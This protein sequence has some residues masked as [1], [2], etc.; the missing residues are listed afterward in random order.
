MTC[1]II[2]IDSQENFNNSLEEFD[3]NMD[4]D[5]I[6][7]FEKTEN[8]Y[9]CFYKKMPNEIKGFFI[10]INKQQLIINI[11]QK[12]IKLVSNSTLLKNELL[13]LIHSH[14]VLNCI[15]YSLKSLLKYNIT[16]NNIDIDKYLNNSNFNDYFKNI[17]T[18][19]DIKY[20]E[21]IEMM[22]NLN[23]LYFI[24]YELD[25]LDELDKL[26]SKFKSK[27]N[28]TKKVMISVQK[29]KKSYGNNKTKKIYL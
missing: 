14:S 13:Q 22:H 23:S 8:L 11:K 1:K 10:Y 3:D 17:T 12:N 15:N 28:V 16:L 29:Q 26:N 7:S 25:E 24:F 9:D 27:H 2:E 19:K 21:T 6:E 18:I 4:D 5:W 20:D